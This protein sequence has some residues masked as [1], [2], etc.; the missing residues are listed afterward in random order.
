[1]HPIFFDGNTYSPDEG[2]ILAYDRNGAAY[3]AGIY[4]DS[5]GD[6]AIAFEKSTDSI[7]WSDSGIALARSGDLPSYC[8]MTADTS[9]DSPY[10][11]SIYVSCVMI[12]PPFQFTQNQVVVSHSNDGGMTWHVVNVA[13]VQQSPVEDWY[14]VMTVGKDG[15]VY[16]TWQACNTSMACFNNPV[17]MVFSKSTDGG[18]TWSKP[19]LVA[20]VTPIYP[21]PNTKFGEAQDIP[22]IA[23]D[24]SDGPYS[25]NLYVVM[26]N[27]TGSFMQV[28]V[29]RSTDGGTT[30]SKPVPVAPGITHDQFL[31]WIAVSPTGLVGVTWADRRNDPN[32]VNYQAFAAISSD[33]GLSFEPNIQLTNA[34]SNPNIGFGDYDGATWDGPNYFLAAWMDES[35]GVNTQDFVG[36]IRLK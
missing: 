11:N 30:W 13:P 23:V 3:I 34:F 36:G 27:W 10:L 20:K 5:N 17:Y 26:Y 22:A 2:P 24:N 18:S 14:T 4:G 9:A 6:A 21:I 25:G 16:L 12:G 7:H 29:A 32:N 35:N 1:M 28:V 19:R 33:G 31:P 15:A 8:W